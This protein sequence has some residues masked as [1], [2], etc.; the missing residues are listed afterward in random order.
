MFKKKMVKR[1]G[2]FQMHTLILIPGPLPWG[3]QIS[4]P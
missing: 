1:L 2:G 4:T 3:M